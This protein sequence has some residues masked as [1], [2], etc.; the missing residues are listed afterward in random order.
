M[1]IIGDSGELK[2]QVFLLGFILTGENAA[3]IH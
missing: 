1:S 2:K 3:I